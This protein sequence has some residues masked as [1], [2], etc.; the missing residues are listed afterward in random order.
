[1]ADYRQELEALIDEGKKFTFEN[2][3]SR[4]PDG[5]YPQAYSPE[6][7][8]WKHKV[9]AI[10]A[11][12]GKSPAGQSLRVGLDAM[13]LGQR[14][15]DFERAKAS[16][17]NGLKAALALPEPAAVIALA[18]KQNEKT[19]RSN[20]I[21]I[22]HGHDHEAKNELELFLKTHGLEAV[23]LHRQPDEG[24]TII[25]KFEKHSDVGYAFILLTPDDVGGTAETPPANLSKRARQN[26]IFEFGYFAGKLGRPNVCCIYTGNVELP[27]DL[28]GL[29]YKEFHKNIR[30]VFYDI[31]GELKA[32]GYSLR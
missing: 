6:W 10:E 23:V 27:S 26:V 3:A 15:D 20:R 1:V 7:I 21:F 30:E 24:K 14:V 17:L 25:E 11:L 31:Q 5:F 22:V 8:V 9:Q 18:N 13:I 32:R 19:E 4:G 28:D 2:F 16:I 12:H 29:I